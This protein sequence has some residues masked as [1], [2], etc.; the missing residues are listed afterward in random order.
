MLHRAVLFT[1]VALALGPGCTAGRTATGDAGPVGPG[2]DSGTPPGND[3]YVA[4]VD[5]DIVTASAPSD[6]PTMFGGTPDASHAPSLVYPLDGVMVPPNLSQLEFHYLPNGGT[7][8]QLA[9]TAGTSRIRVYFG[10]PESVGAGCV[11]M[12]DHD[13]WTVISSAARGR[14][15]I[16]YVLRGV[17]ASG[18][19][20]ETTSQTITFANQDVTGGVYY[21]TPG[22]NG[23]INRFEF[24]VPGARAEHFLNVATT[25]ATF[26]IGCHTLSRD[27]ALIAVGE[28]TV[29]SRF[30]VF[31][32]ETRAQRF[33]LRGMGT[34][35]P[36]AGPAQSN[37]TSFSPDNA[38]I[39][40]SS[41]AGLRFLSVADGSVLEEG[42]TGAAASMP[43]WSPDGEHIVY[44]SFPGRS[45]LGLFDSNG[46]TSGSIVRLDRVGGAWTVGPTLVASSGDNNFHPSYSPDGQFVIYNRSPSNASS[47]G[48]DP[49]GGTSRMSDAQMWFV[50]SS[51]TGAAVSLD[52]IHGLSDQWP[53]FNPTSFN[54]RGHPLFWIVW[55]SRRGYGLR[56]D[57]DVRS[58]LWM[59]S[60]DPMRAAAGLD[61]TSVPFWMPF[62]NMEETNHLAQWVSTVRRMGCDTDAECGGEFC[63]DHRCFQEPPVF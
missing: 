4:P 39:V 23:A 40:G 22:A 57:E 26:C 3:A 47:I 28:D 5:V 30:E 16:T 29:T 6:A 43:D 24:G 21:W 45:T 59:A 33:L 55:A 1:L 10:C 51:G 49:G 54:E 63:V 58:Q 35:G 17:S 2:T 38:Q 37:F 11:F 60:F 25:A 52:A 12:P 56:L 9:F 46:I 36:L 53:R 7:V 32:I 14:G 8:F 20:G 13:T 44:V 61:P 42:V 31:D 27:G 34:G 15:P 18:A 19:L 48:D 41:F 50:P 62:Q